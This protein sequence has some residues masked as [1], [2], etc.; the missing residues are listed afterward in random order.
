[1]RAAARPLYFSSR[2]PLTRAKGFASMPATEFAIRGTPGTAS[3]SLG[4]QG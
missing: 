2:T 1:M 4:V 3:N